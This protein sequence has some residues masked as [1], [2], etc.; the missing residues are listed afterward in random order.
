[1]RPDQHKQKRSAQYKK[2]HGIKNQDASRTKEKTGTAS[3]DVE[4]GT[5][6]ADAS[7]PA[8]TNEVKST[9]AP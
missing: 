3:G 5:A 2:K 9:D 1:M 4:P 6:E 8:V 7:I